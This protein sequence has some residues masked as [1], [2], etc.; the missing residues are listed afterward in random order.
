[1]KELFIPRGTDLAIG[2]YQANRSPT[3]W[4]ADADV[5]RPERWLE[6]A[7]SDEERFKE[8]AST[9]ELAFGYGKFQ[10]LGKT[11]AAMELNK[12]FEVTCPIVCGDDAV[13]HARPSLT[14]ALVAS[15][16]V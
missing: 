12:V 15:A 14:A 11:I 9:V 1:M 7:E 16:T 5:W 6:A 4:G 3:L 2:I 8:M 10:C 13:G